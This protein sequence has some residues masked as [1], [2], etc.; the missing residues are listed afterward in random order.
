MA[1]FPRKKR[2]ARKPLIKKKNEGYFGAGIFWGSG[3]ETRKIFIMQIAFSSYWRVGREM[4]K[5][6]GLIT[7][8]EPDHRIPNALT[9]IK[10]LGEAETAI[11]SRINS[12]LGIMGF[13]A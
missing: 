9:K 11:R 1:G 3:D 6:M 5:A 8:L 13:L 7:L 2:G 4:K 12:R 10:F